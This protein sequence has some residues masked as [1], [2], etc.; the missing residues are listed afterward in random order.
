M[1]E[2]RILATGAGSVGCINFLRSLSCS[3]E[4]FYI[5][6]IDTNEFYLI[7]NSYL[8]KRYKAPKREDPSFIDFINHLCSEERVDFIH[9]NPEPEL[10]ILSQN[11]EKIKAKTL[12]ARKEVVKISRDKYLTYEK[13]KGKINMPTTRLYSEEN[14]E[15]LAREH[16]FPLWIRAR[17]GAGGR[18]SLPIYSLEEARKWVE[19]WNLKKIDKEEFMIQEFLP[20]KDVAWD[21]LWFKGKLYASFTRERLFYIY[22]QLSPSGITGTP[23]VARTIKDEKVNELC[24]RAVKNMDSNPS[25]FYCIDIKYDRENAP[26]ITEVNVKVHTTLGLWCHLS[27]KALNLDWSYNLPYIYVKAG[28]EDNLPNEPL[29]TDILPEDVTLIRHLDSGVVILKNRE[30][31]RIM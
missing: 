22:P 17:K 28:L 8:N 27:L 6:G 19:L 10:E 13:L 7:L 24:I 1:K 12:I 31:I 16:G 20:G 18:L 30:V 3:P 23:T 29:G 4:K 9:P 5:V 15:E 11:I 25:G 21:S 2:I 14:L 26:K